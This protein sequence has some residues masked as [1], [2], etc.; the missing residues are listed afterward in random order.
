MQL[1]IVV[2]QLAFIHCALAYDAEM[3]RN[4]MP[5]HAAL[6][7]GALGFIH[8][9][10]PAVSIVSLNVLLVSEACRQGLRIRM[11]LPLA[12]LLTALN[13]LGF[14]LGVIDGVFCPSIS[15]MRPHSLMH[16]AIAGF[17]YYGGLFLDRGILIKKKEREQ[18]TSLRASKQG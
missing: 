9:L 5:L 18:G 2:A 1:S 6:V 3:M 13:I 14:A 8:P 7:L 12:T 10:L 4:H 16:I 17:C 11:L 15:F